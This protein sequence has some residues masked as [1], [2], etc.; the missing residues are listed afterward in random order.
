ML[1]LVTTLLLAA[2]NDTPGSLLDAPP[3]LRIFETTAEPETAAPTLF[4]D[5]KDPRFAIGLTIGYNQVDG[6]DDGTYFYGLFARLYFGLLAVEGSVSTSESEFEDGDGEATMVPIQVSAL[7]MPFPI[8][9]FRPYGLAGVGWY[10][11]D[12]NYSGGL[13]TLEDESD[14]TFGAHL[15]LGTELQLG[16]FVLFFDVRYVYVDDPDLDTDLEDF[17]YYSIN[18]GAAIGF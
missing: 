16:R 6:A 13:S 10:Y 15:G 4:A 9:P 14:S 7:L 17:S 11:H 12:V 5:E 3:H 1:T 8:G 18:L 2:C